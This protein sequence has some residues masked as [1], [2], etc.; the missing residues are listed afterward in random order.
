MLITIMLF[1]L[2]LIFFLDDDYNYDYMI[3]ENLI[4]IAVMIT[5]LSIGNRNRMIMD[6][7]TVMYKTTCIS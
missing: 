2:Q 3:F 4:A 6:K 5:M 7:T 1:G